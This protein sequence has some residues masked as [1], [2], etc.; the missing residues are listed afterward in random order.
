MRPDRDVWGYV[1]DFI[2]GLSLFITLLA[3]AFIGYGLA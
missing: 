3:I 2:G 1:A